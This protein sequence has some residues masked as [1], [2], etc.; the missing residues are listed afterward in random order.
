MAYAMLEEK[1]KKI[2]E[3]MKIMGLNDT[4]FYLSWIIYY[5]TIY[6]IIAVLGTIFVRITIFPSSNFILIL[7]WY[8]LFCINL[9]MQ[10]MMI[11]TF[12][13]RAKLGNVFGMVLFF[14][15]YIVS[16]VIGNN[17]DM[18]TGIRMLL[19]VFP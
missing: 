16:S 11:T 5:G 17:K 19:S 18:G 10:S 15:L 4:A 3:S 6:L 14:S 1:E 2:K 13:T 9:M 12:F 8:I 7:I